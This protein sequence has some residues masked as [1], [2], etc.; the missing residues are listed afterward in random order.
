MAELGID[1]LLR[2][3][4]R[5]PKPHHAPLIAD[6]DAGELVCTECAAAYPVRD[7]L[8]VMLVDEARETR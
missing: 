7:G 6:V 1:P 4:L 2:E 3:L 8:P 5:C